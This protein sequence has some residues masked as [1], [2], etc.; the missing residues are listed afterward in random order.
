MYSSIFSAMEKIPTNSTIPSLLNIGVHRPEQKK[1]KKE[2]C[3][4]RLELERKEYQSRLELERLSR[5]K[6]NE[7]IEKKNSN[8]AKRL[9][10]EKKW[11]GDGMNPKN[12]SGHPNFPKGEDTETKETY[13]RKNRNLRTKMRKKEIKKKRKNDPT[14]KSRSR[15]INYLKLQGISY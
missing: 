15:R 10:K 6:E 9:R 8:K 13:H 11:I 5:I 3:Q 7:Q 4:S 1:T 14:V 12:L 2:E